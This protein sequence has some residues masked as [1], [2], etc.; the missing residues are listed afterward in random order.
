M[1]TLFSQDED[2]ES[3]LE[4]EP[5]ARTVW[6]IEGDEEQACRMRRDQVSVDEGDERGRE[7]DAQ[8]VVK[9]ACSWG[10]RKSGEPRDGE[11]LG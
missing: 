4:L 10:E 1:P 9:A 2:G 5:R 8:K 6:R 11:R 3:E 7:V